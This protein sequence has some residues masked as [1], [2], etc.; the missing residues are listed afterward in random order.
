MRL[1]ALIS[2]TDVRLLQ[3]GA[4][5]IGADVRIC[6]I[7]EDSR[8]VMPGSLFIARRGEKSDGR[9][10]VDGAIRAGAVAVLTDDPTFRPAGRPAGSAPGGGPGGGLGGGPGPAVLIT[11]DIMLACAMLAE[12]FYGEPT[13]HLDLVGV[14]GTK[15]KTTTT[16]LIHQL[17]N[18]AGTRTGL[19]GTVCIDDG[20][21]VAPA[22][23][24]TPP[25]MEL[26]RTF[27]RMLECGCKAA[28]MEVSSHALRQQRVAA[29][30]FRVGVFTNLTHDH[31][32]YHKTMEAYA[33]AKAM[34]FEHLPAE[35]RRGVAIINA[36]DPWAARMVRD[37][38][39][40]VIACAVS[41][42]GVDDLPAN[43]VG[44]PECVAEILTLDAGGMDVL[45]R[46]PWGRWRLRLPLVGPHNA[47]NA[48]QAAV[49]A[50]EMG[51][52]PSEVE[53]A[54]AGVSPPPGRLEPVTGAEDPFAV[55]VDYAHTDD[56]LRRVLEV[57]RQLGPARVHVVF[58]CGGDRDRAKRPK[59]GGVAA[60][61]ADAV[62][63]TSDN[64]RTEDP[65]SII[66]QV[67]AGAPPDARARVTV[68]PD[69][70]R[71][72]H[73]AIGAAGPGDI[74]LIAG[75]GHEDYQILPDGAGG[76]MKR[77]FD[78]RE[79]ARAALRARG[80]VTIGVRAG[81]G[82]RAGS[83][84]RGGRGDAAQRGQDEERE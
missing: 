62:I 44:E 70:E 43:T 65:L 33:A 21:E 46:G 54:L 63:I 28:A 10:F 78:D 36:M 24:T 67:L 83:G 34:L 30:R 22:Q 48:L 68:E 50:M 3:H 27:A 49:A 23:L 69:R 25:A 12:R 5:A 29:L 9:A 81:R 19:I 60:A 1:D 6:D 51:L 57:A 73:A 16:W 2:G 47:M 71:A 66:D 84:G 13:A 40:R 32:D 52:A 64:P 72:I 39:A 35:A 61:L 17:L 55:Y 76:T 53:A 56:S 42:V 7:T 20:S 38:P 11:S 8:T 18:G 77:R 80:I 15:G 31:L 14:T 41:G 37:C 58:G 45:L 26:S 59:M 82:S 75:K 4:G 74:V 79:V